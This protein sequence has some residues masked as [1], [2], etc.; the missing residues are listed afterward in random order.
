MR[1]NKIVKGMLLKSVVCIFISQ[2]ACQSGKIQKEN[3]GKS[4]VEESTSSSIKMNSDGNFELRSFEEKTIAN[5]LKLL[6]IKDATLPKISLQMMVNSGT[7][8]DKATEAGLTHLMMLL[9]DQGNGQR[10]ALQMADAF[11]ELGSSF[12]RSTGPDFLTLSTTGLSSKK[13]EL[14]QL[15]GDVILLPKFS[16]AE[17]ERKRSQVIAAI[18][19]RPDNP[20]EFASD[21]MEKEVFQGHTYGIASEGEVATVKTLTRTKIIKSFYLHFRPQNAQLMITGNFDDEFKVQV[22]KL[23][24]K[25]GAR[26]GE[27]KESPVVAGSPSKSRILVTQSGLKQAQIRFSQVMIPRNH[28]D[29]LKLRLANLVLGGSFESRLNRRVRDELGLTYSIH[30]S[31]D[32]R[33]QGGSFDIDTFSRQEKTGE[34]IKETEGLLREFV[35]NGITQ[36]ELDA[37]KTLMI[38]QFPA[39]IETTERFGFNLM[40]L[41]RNNVGDDYLKNFLKNVEQLSLKEVNAAIK[42]H[43]LPEKTKVLVYADASQVQKQMEELGEVEVRKIP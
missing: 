2:T 36:N 3:M 41:R 31:L 43:M 1:K 6:F 19:K 33:V 16:V 30:S 28:P 21:L 15:M 13:N 8:Q 25:W 4:A 14:L 20:T 9:I 40:Y 29:F 5:G 35:K 22:E 11:A 12:N 23:F 26:K 34:V 18:Q 24:S 32:S 10:D 17:I 37:A 7:S 27:I 38:G 39:S 42:E